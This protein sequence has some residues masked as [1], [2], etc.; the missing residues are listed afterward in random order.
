[1]EIWGQEP[2]ARIQWFS[3]KLSLEVVELLRPFNQKRG[4][5]TLLL[6]LTGD[7]GHNSFLKEIQLELH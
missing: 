6:L 3:S 2:Q 7:P 4:P 1:M 5:S